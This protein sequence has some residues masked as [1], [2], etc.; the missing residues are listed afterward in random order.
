MSPLL[1]E[2][3]WQPQ[4]IAAIAL[5]LSLLAVIRRYLT[6]SAFKLPLPPGPPGNIIFGNSLPPALCV[7]L[8]LRDR[9]A[10]LI[11]CHHEVLTG[12]LKN[13]Q[14]NTVQYSH[15]VKG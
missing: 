5:C 14:N 6:R 15:F 2:I 12:S 1:L 8:V 11:H 4:S 10:Q 3:A 13:G 9:A 7:F